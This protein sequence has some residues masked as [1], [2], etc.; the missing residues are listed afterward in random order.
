M[1]TQRHSLT[2]LAEAYDDLFDDY[3]ASQDYQRILSERLDTEQRR[4]ADLEFQVIT[5]QEQCQQRAQE[6]DSLSGQLAAMTTARDELK[7][8]RARPKVDYI[9][10]P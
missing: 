5:L 1:P 7:A 8:S 6:V 3:Q 10:R 9:E 4:V 2:V